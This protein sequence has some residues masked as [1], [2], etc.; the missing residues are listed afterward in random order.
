[1]WGSTLGLAADSPFLLKSQTYRDDWWVEHMLSNCL[2][3]ASSHTSLKLASH[4][5][6]VVFCSK[7]PLNCML[8]SPAQ[9]SPVGTRSEKSVMHL[10]PLWLPPKSTTTGLGAETIGA[11]LRSVCQWLPCSFL[12]S[13]PNIPQRCRYSHLPFRTEL[14][15]FLT[16]NFTLLIAK[17]SFFARNNLKGVKE[18]ISRRDTARAH[19][20]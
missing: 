3:Q 9:S 4:V 6:F 1:M 13:L 12:F 20:L 2:S 5:P 11:E 19:L 16:F 10:F 18:A 8:P 17:E 15:E 14:V 7:L